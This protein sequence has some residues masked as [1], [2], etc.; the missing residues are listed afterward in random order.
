M[1]NWI[2]APALFLVSFFLF[3]FQAEAQY[4]Q[5]KYSGTLIVANKSGNTV[6]F[7]DRSTGK[8]IKTL[9]AGLEPHE[10]E[11][12]PNGNY[13]VVT[14]YG[15]RENPG[16][17]LSLYDV[18]NK[19]ISR[20]IDLGENTRPHGIDWLKG[21][22]EFL[23]TTEG[24]Q[25][26]LK[27]DATEGVILKQ[28]ETGEEVSHMVAAA[29]KANKAFVPSIR[30][31]KVA[32]FNLETGELIKRLESGKGAEGIAVTPNEKE[33]WITNRGENTISIFDTRSLE[34]IEKMDCGDFPIRAKFSPNGKYFVVSNA[35]SGHVAIVDARKRKLI[36]KIKLTPPV[37]EDKDPERYFS[38]FEGTS[39]PIGVVVP[40]NQTAYV[41]N[42]RSDV[43]TLIDLEKL[44]IAEHFPV[45]KEPGGINYS[46]VK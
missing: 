13:A 7:V 24:S 31:G 41:A 27:I 29:P 34:L 42:T 12:S 44:E 16:N 18:K 2:Y 11:V 38:E 3:T 19:K 8:V 26:L 46:P 37:P 10:V 43:I 40:D 25:R 5:K 14:N 22:S 1:K 39:V 35:K 9:P 23:V 36:E 32:V 15:D 33:V 4:S 45:G 28:Y 21:T 17:S 20:T 6:S 30:T